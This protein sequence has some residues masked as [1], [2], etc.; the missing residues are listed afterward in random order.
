M[1]DEVIHV[2]AAHAQR[3]WP[4]HQQQAARAP[5]RRA[6]PVLDRRDDDEL[7]RPA[8]SLH[9]ALPPVGGQLRRDPVRPV[10][11]L[12]VRVAA[13]TE[14]QAPAIVR[15][16]D[17]H[18]LA[19]HEAATLGPTTEDPHRGRELGRVDRRRELEAVDAALA[20]LVDACR[21]Q[22]AEADE[23]IDR[24]DEP[25]LGQRGPRRTHDASLEIARPVPCH[26][27]ERILAKTQT[28][29]GSVASLP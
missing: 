1:E 15:A 9:Q 19:A 21:W 24:A 16:R 4:F 27:R 13:R 18:G 17:V 3:P 8:L 6:G 20:P 29:D 22:S 12:E 25:A 26:V 10:G 5:A 2:C 14:A 11:A 23:H 7:G 28:R